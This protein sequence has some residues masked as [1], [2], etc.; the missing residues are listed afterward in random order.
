ME[1]ISQLGQVTQTPGSASEQKGLHLRTSAPAG[2]FSWVNSDHFLTGCSRLLVLTLQLFSRECCFKLTL[3]SAAEIHYRTGP[4]LSPSQHAPHSHR[5][6]HFCKRL[7]GR[8]AVRARDR[9]TQKCLQGKLQQD[10]RAGGCQRY[11]NISVPRFPKIRPI[12]LNLGRQGHSS[13]PVNQNF[14]TPSTS[15]SS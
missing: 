9:Q 8:G 15:E 4:G 10:G 2:Y 5:L 3:C 6:A 13:H 7:P 14:K 1:E 11:A 12:M